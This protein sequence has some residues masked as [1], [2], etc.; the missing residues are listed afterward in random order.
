MF[1]AILVNEQP[2]AVSLVG[3]GCQ[4][5]RARSIGV[6]SGQ[7]S[8]PENVIDWLKCLAYQLRQL[9]DIHR[10]PPGLHREK[11]RKSSAGCFVERS[12][13]LFGKGARRRQIEKA[14]A[15]INLPVSERSTSKSPRGVVQLVK[16][17]MAPPLHLIQ[18]RFKIQSQ[19]CEGAAGIITIIKRRTLKRQT[20]VTSTSHF[21]LI[22]KRAGWDDTK[23]G[24]NL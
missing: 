2:L 17:A 14:P 1:A 6:S 4:G 20:D 11:R 7:K 23:T 8:A 22:F 24:D 18:T 16:T 15:V 21:M 9:R 10:N 3:G 19:I 13:K 5:P 12:A